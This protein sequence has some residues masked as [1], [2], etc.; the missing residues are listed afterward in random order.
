VIF[1]AAI[2]NIDKA[3]LRVSAE[4]GVRMAGEGIEEGLQNV[5][6]PVFRNI[7][8]GESHRIEINADTWYQMLIGAIT[9]G[10]LE[11]APT[12]ARNI[13]NTRAGYAVQQAQKVDAL[14]TNALILDPKTE[15]GKLAG[16]LA[17][18]SIHENQ[19]NI[20]ELLRAYVDAGGD[21]TFMYTP[22]LDTLL[23]GVQTQDGEILVPELPDVD[24]VLTVPTDVRLQNVI[25][26]SIEANA[27]IK[28]ESVQAALTQGM[29]SLTQIEARIK[30]DSGNVNHQGI[31]C[32]GGGYQGSCCDRKLDR[33]GSGA[34]A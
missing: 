2:L 33:C 18:G 31:G 13:S 23:D 32:N 20:G 26:S 29:T 1:H 24:A 28:P 19:Y 30:A 5:L 10:L 27:H 4:L 6:E 9:A 8:L 7:A 12:V 15:A 17:D 3:L 21:T 16:K 22:N 14:I 11:G 34:A 25:Q